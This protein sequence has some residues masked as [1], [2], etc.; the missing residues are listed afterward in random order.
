[1][2]PCALFGIAKLLGI[3]ATGRRVTARAPYPCH[4]G[5]SRDKVQAATLKWKQREMRMEDRTISNSY[6]PELAWALP[7]VREMGLTWAW[8][9]WPTPPYPQHVWQ[10]PFPTNTGGVS[11]MEPRLYLVQ[12]SGEVVLLFF[13]LPPNGVSR[14]W[15]IICF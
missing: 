3:V 11:H 15:H 13:V 4:T 9:L 12:P 2:P 6:P 5:I 10:F 7:C 1:M 8:C 14:T